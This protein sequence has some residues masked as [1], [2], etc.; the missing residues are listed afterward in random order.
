M[1]SLGEKLVRVSLYWQKT[2]E[3]RCL[4]LALLCRSGL[5]GG[6]NG[7]ISSIWAWTAMKVMQN[8][9]AFSVSRKSLDHKCLHKLCQ[10]IDMQFLM[11]VPNICSSWKGMPCY[12]R[13]DTEVSK[14]EVRMEIITNTYLKASSSDRKWSNWNREVKILLLLWPA[15]TA[16]IWKNWSGSIVI[17][18][19]LYH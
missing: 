19:T 3:L 12:L 5:G 9:Q 16:W 14:L 6:G 13:G 15:Q 4:L 17:Y 10:P 8:F 2:K 11:Y 7:H 1:P 18:P